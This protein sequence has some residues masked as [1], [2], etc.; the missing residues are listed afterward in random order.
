MTKKPEI[1]LTKWETENIQYDL[2]NYELIVSDHQAY[3]LGYVPTTRL[4]K[5]RGRHDTFYTLLVDTKGYKV[6][7]KTSNPQLAEWSF[8]NAPMTSY[9]Q[10]TFNIIA[11]GQKM[12]NVIDKKV[13]KKPRTKKERF[14][15]D[16]ILKA[17]YYADLRPDD[18]DDETV[19]A[20][21]ANLASIRPSDLE[22]IILP[23]K[24]ELY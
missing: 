21:K 13:N 24:L 4:Q 14:E 11:K 1:K 5:L 9:V 17:I 10:E 8:Y 22:V 2:D 12:S 7:S 15:A 20:V 6:L 16:P 3:Y 19:L 23:D 18:T